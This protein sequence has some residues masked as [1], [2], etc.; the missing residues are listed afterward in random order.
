MRPMSQRLK[1]EADASRRSFQCAV[2]G[3]ESSRVFGYVSEGD[4]PVAVYHADLYVN[5]AHSQAAVVLTISIG[6]WREEAV[7]TTRHRARLEVKPEGNE[8][9][10]SFV[11]F[12]RGEKLEAELG[13]TLTGQEARQSSER[14]TYLQVADAVVY[15]D[16]RVGRTLGISDRLS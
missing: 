10:M 15:G 11:D 12:A 16:D 7:P 14:D 6:D 3:S 5:H 1:I 2:C 4:S 9:V 8:V 13:T